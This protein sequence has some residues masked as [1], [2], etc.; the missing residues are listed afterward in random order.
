MYNKIV[1]SILLA[2]LLLLETI[3]ASPFQIKV[4]YGHLITESNLI[5]KKYP[6]FVCVCLS[7]CG[8]LPIITKWTKLASYPVWPLAWARSGKKRK[9]RNTDMRHTYYIQIVNA[10]F[11][12]FSPGYIV[13]ATCVCLF[14]PTNVVRPAPAVR[15]DS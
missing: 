12:V 11:G 13:T 4:F 15:L 9:K 14:V 8:Y 6:A 10:C 3:A 5:K 2:F 7:L 1:F